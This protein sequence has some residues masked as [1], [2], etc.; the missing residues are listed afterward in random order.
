MT[1]EDWVA[2]TSWTDVELTQDDNMSGL[3][4]PAEGGLLGRIPQ[5]LRLQTI[6]Q[7][8][9]VQRVPVCV[10]VAFPAGKKY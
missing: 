6:M 10:A 9:R 7:N 5:A 2:T 8:R 4:V 1:Q 3:D